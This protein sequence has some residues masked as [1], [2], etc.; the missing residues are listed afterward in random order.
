MEVE[1]TIGSGDHNWKWR[2][3]LEVEI[4]I[5]SGDRNWK[6][7]SQ[8]EVEITIQSALTTEL[9][10]CLAINVFIGGFQV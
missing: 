9:N 8:L 5:G 4:A 3:Q 1:I 10:T 6:W 7:R 2:S